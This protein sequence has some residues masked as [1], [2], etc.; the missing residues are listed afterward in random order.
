MGKEII[1]DLYITEQ[2]STTDIGKRLGI[3]YSTVRRFLLKY[4][5]LRSRTE[6]IRLA[7]YKIGIRTKE[8]KRHFTDEW[9]KNISLGSI[10]RWDKTSKGYC[11]KLNG[12][13]EITRGKNKGR[14]L[15]AVIYEQFYNLKLDENDIVHHINGIRTDN[16]IRNLARMTKSE[17]CS[18][19]AKENYK[20]RTINKKGQFT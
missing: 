8:T 4:N 18:L 2:L 10:R 20:N 17:H 19:H 5:L 14:M 15:H 6:G 11:L 1:Y 12:Y 3:S 13:Y 7:S 9:K 16:D